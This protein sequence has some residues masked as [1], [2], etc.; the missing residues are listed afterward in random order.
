MSPP[1]SAPPSTS[2]RRSAGLRR[3]AILA[4]LAFGCSVVRVPVSELGEPSTPARGTIAD[5]QIEL[6]LE[7]GGAVLPGEPE[8]ALAES[9]AA[10]ASALEGRGAPEAQSDAVLYVRER[11]VARTDSRRHDQIAAGVGLA[12]AA[13]AVVAIVV[14]AIVSGKGGGG[15]GASKA[16][17]AAP[18]ASGGVVAKAASAGARPA[19]S[20]ARAVG[21]SA[22][23]GS[24]V[25]SAP[26]LAP[27][28]GPTPATA[29]RPAPVGG[30]R[31]AP[32]AGPRPA[33]AP[34]AVSSPGGGDVQVVAGIDVEVPVPYPGEAAVYAQESAPVEAPP[35]GSG[36]E[37]DWGDALPAPPVAATVLPPPAPLDVV[38]RGFFAGDETVL[39]LVLVDLRTGRT[40]WQKTVREDCD[41]RDRAA[42]ARALE[43]ALRGQPAFAHRSP[44]A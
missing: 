9:R 3:I 13:V 22:R 25:A 11:A 8:L 21:G 5:P 29:P 16:L 27:A 33:L 24:V 34:G 43:R 38:G 36:A 20:A 15:G 14:L 44:R 31:P 10:L 7:G 4:L 35:E 1:R 40:L 28:P 32:V 17:A 19:A 42:V 41:P 30:P 12:V 37:E 18:R 26:R 2:P 39:D 6:W 23:A